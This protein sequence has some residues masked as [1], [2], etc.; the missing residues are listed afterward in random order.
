ML[1]VMAEFSFLSLIHFLGLCS[2]MPTADLSWTRLSR[3][4]LQK[5]T[6][7]FSRSNIHQTM[8]NHRLLTLYMVWIRP[9]TYMYNMLKVDDSAP[10]W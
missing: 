4:Q 9:C 3:L 2:T 5:M 7:I 6:V 10:V 8:Q 1:V